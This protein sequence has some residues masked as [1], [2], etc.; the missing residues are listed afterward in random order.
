MLPEDMEPGATGSHSGGDETLGLSSLNATAPRNLGFKTVQ[1]P[2]FSYHS[3]PSRAMRLGALGVLP[4]EYCTLIAGWVGVGKPMY[5]TLT[6]SW[7]PTDPSP[8]S[9]PLVITD[10]LANATT[11]WWSHRLAAHSIPYRGHERTLH[12]SSSNK[13]PTIP[14]WSLSAQ[15]SHVPWVLGVAPGGSLRELL[16][17]ACKN[18]FGLLLLSCSQ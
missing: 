17:S 9:N 7:A 15:R 8:I 13:I 16:P 6:V 11:V 12:R 4:M 1:A 10:G 5:P 3:H 2:L 14:P 18:V